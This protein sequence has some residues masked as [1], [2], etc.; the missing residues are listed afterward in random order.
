MADMGIGQVAREAGVRPSTVRYYESI[1]LLPEPPRRSGRRRYD[2]GVLHRLAIIQ[3]AQQA[4]FS[5]DEMRILFD[6]LPA[7]EYASA[8]WRSLVDYKL[9]QLALLMRNVLS[10]KALLEDIR[11]CADDELAECVYLTG[12]KHLQKQ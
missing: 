11:S 12:Q 10:M 2:P 3:T 1:G 4:G 5:L 9:Q 8:Q 6:D 7:S